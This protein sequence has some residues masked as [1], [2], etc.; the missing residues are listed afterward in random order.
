MS[1]SKVARRVMFGGVSPTQGVQPRGGFSMLQSGLP[2]RGTGQ[3]MMT[4]TGLGNRAVP[5]GQSSVTY[6]SVTP[7]NHLRTKKTYYY[8]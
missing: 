8:G 2:S 7:I 5:N 3:M 1:N 4:F 6:Q